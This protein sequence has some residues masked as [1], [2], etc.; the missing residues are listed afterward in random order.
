MSQLKKKLS[1]HGKNAADILKK[2]DG[3]TGLIY[4]NDNNNPIIGFLP[5]DYIIIQNENYLEFERQ[6][7]NE[8]R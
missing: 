7:L 2:L 1:L 6:N 5:Q 3:L 4:L 8:Y